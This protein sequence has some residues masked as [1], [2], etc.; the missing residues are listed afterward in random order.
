MAIVVFW[1]KSVFNRAE[2]TNFYQTRMREFGSV[3]CKNVGLKLCKNLIIARGHKWRITQNGFQDGSLSP[4]G[5]G[6]ASDL[7]NFQLGVDLKAVH[8]TIHEKFHL[9][10]QE[11]NTAIRFFPFSKPWLSTTLANALFQQRLPEIPAALCK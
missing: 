9:E 4:A 11:K 5:G 3:C 6:R 2:Y 7:M 10:P 1:K 8:S